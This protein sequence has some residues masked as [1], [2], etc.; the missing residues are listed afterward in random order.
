MCG[1]FAQIE[2]VDS[3]AQRLGIDEVLMDT[4]APRYNI[5]P[6]ANVVALVHSIKK[7]LVQLKWGLIPYWVRDISRA[8]PL[9]NARVE[10]VAVKPSFKKAFF[11]NRCIILAS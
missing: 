11:N 7:S 6:G 9:I 3:I 1:R 8:K 2:P 5:S 4:I 10:T